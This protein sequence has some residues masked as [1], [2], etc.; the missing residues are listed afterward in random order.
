MV[1]GAGGADTIVRAMIGLV[2]TKG[3]EI[4]LDAPV[5]AIESDGAA[6]PG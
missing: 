4:R 3:G 5:A 6:R 2:R 1:V